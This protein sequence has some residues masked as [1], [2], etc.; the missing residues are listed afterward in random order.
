MSKAEPQR[1]RVWIEGVYP[2]IDAGRFPIK[3]V[4]GED[5]VV[6]ADAFADG[7]DA[8]SVVLRWRAEG[9]AAE[10]QEAQ[11]ELGW[12]DRWRGSFR[13]EEIGRYRY[14]VVGWVDR[15]RTWRRDLRKKVDAGVDVS[16]DLLVGAELAEAAAKRARGPQRTR[17]RSWA[18]RLEEAQAPEI[19]FDPEL[20]VLMESNP[21]RAFATTYL[22]EL[23]VVVDPPRAGFSSWYEFFPRSCGPDGHHGTFE[24]AERMLPYV[25]RMG[26]DIV[27]LPPIHPIGITNRK[28]KNNAP[29]CEPG[30]IGSPWA[31]GSE[32]GGHT[33]VHPDLGT[34]EDFDRFVAAARRHG[35]EVALDIAYQCSPDHPWVKEHPE[36]FRRLPDGTIRYAENPPKRYEDIYPIDFETE[37]WQELWEGLRGIVDFWIDRGITIFRVDNPHTKAFPFWEWLIGEVKARHP[38]T[39]FLSEAFTRPRVM[40]ALAKLGFTQSY[41]YFTWRNTKWELESYYADLAIVREF[42]RPNL[43]PNT[44]DI[45]PELLQWGGRPAFMS[46]L[47]LAATLGANYGI[48]GPAFEL[49]VSE[50]VAPG[51]EE[52]LH[53]EKY[54][55]RAWDLDDPVSLADLIGRINQIRRNNPALHT[56]RTL[57]FHPVDN[58]ELIAYSKVSD[59][60]E[61]A[62]LTVV[63]LDPNH[64]RSGFVSLPLADLGISEE[65]P[66]QVHDLLTDARYLWQGPHNYVEVDPHSIPAHIFRLRHRVRTEHDFDYFM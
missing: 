18:K 63:N 12:N 32:D 26:F 1:R 4:P 10:W 23:E 25:A 17:L 38:E 59:D 27:Y 30:D 54:E 34:L 7:H 5:V 66:Y 31:I 45:L 41:T 42:F 49:C 51:R 61:N 64:A 20:R 22:R 21:D 57:R 15:F 13:V 24:D 47:I 46:R 44:P 29:Q 14:T 56:D 35:L 16:V 2:E 40:Y 36:W 3:R 53:S 19:A 8:L 37:G 65:H 50:A 6:E 62:I 58:E 43:W 39:I 48:Y 60:G 28:G 11:M 33:A 9:A 55:L 52:Y